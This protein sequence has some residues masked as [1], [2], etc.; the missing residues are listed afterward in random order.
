MIEDQEII[1]FPFHWKYAYIAIKDM[2]ALM[3]RARY[4]ANDWVSHVPHTVRNTKSVTRFVKMG[5]LTVDENRACLEIKDEIRD[6]MEY[7]AAEL[8]LRALIPFGDH[9][10]DYLEKAATLRQIMKEAGVYKRYDFLAI[11]REQGILTNGHIAFRLTEKEREMMTAGD[12][13]GELDLEEALFSGG[14]KANRASIPAKMVAGLIRSVKGEGREIRDGVIVAAPGLEI[15]D[16]LIGIQSR[17]WFFMRKRYP[18]ARIVRL[19]K[20]K[21]QHGVSFLQDG[22]SVGII[23]GARFPKEILNNPYATF[24]G[25]DGRREK[26]LD[27]ADK[28]GVS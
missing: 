10:E 2:R 24:F 8:K 1:R 20:D 3:A 21:F 7:M 6:A 17:Y 9:L 11:A 26:L 5:W 27:L 19:S 18:D 15:A 14:Y 13:G 22:K 12:R 23:M 16:A 4:F 25:E 28:K